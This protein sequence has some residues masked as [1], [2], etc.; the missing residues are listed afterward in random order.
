MPLDDDCLYLIYAR[1]HSRVLLTC[2]GL[3]RGGR[4]TSANTGHRIA[5]ELRQRGGK[6]I[7]VGKANQ[8]ISRVIGKL[9]FYQESWEP[10][11]AAGP[12]KVT[13]G[14][15]GAV[16]HCGI[17]GLAVDD[18]PGDYKERRPDRLGHYIEAIENEQGQ[19]YL[20]AMRQLGLHKRKPRG[21]PF[22]RKAEGVTLSL[23]PEYE[24]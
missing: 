9:L 21:R 2:D 11:F 5:A 16:R 24:Q 23:G 13:I 20:R 3:T 7:T 4:L 10:F 14:K 18:V 8:P 19:A 6:I 12:G 1:H 17:C 15:V 22:P